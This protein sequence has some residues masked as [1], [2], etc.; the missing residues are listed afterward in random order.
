MAGALS[1]GMTCLTAG[2]PG[3]TSAQAEGDAA[4]QAAQPESAGEPAIHSAN[5]GSEKVP[6][7][8]AQPFRLV[9]PSTGSGS[10][11]GRSRHDSPR[12]ATVRQAH[13]PE[14]NQGTSS[15]ESGGERVD[16]PEKSR[17]IVTADYIIGPEDVL[18]VTVWRNQELSKQVAVRPDGRISLPLIG[19]VT[20]VGKTP[21][22]LTEEITVKLKDYK[23][24]P[25]VAIVVRE[26]NSYSIFVLGE[27][28]KPGRY[29]LKSKTTLL[30]GITIAGGFTQVAARNN[31]V[32]F[33][34]GDNGKGEEKLKASYDDIVLRENS[35]QNIE[36]KPGDTVVVPSETMVLIP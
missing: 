10:P 3:I 27:V 7:V 31:L 20:A 8:T 21:A 29:P 24:N 9:D 15:V 36:L 16:P 1:L 12:P 17:L 22:L 14:E 11:R 25:N 32:V 26:V 35:G 6:A 2:W 33:R 23:E 28:T 34:L 30:Q 19:D 13:R 18:E 4:K 5:E